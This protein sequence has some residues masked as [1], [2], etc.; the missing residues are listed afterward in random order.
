MVG[1]AMGPVFHDQQPI[2]DRLAAARPMACGAWRPGT[3][4]WGIDAGRKAVADGADAFRQR[5]SIP[6]LI[7]ASR[8]R[9]RPL[10]DSGPRT[11]IVAVWD[12]GLSPRPWSI[13]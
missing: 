6:R 12:Q 1:R 5:A 8:S 9:S 11:R 7:N 2:V 10:S 13:W 4:A 3:Q